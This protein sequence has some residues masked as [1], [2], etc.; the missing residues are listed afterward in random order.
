M[1]DLFEAFF[2]RVCVAQLPQ[3]KPVRPGEWTFMQTVAH[4]TAAA[5]IYLH[6]LEETVQ[7]QTFSLPNLRARTDLARLNEQEIAKRSQL[8]L[9][10]LSGSF[11]QALQKT[12][13]ITQHL[14]VSELSLPVALPI[15]NR[16]LTIAELLDMQIVHPGMLHADQLTRLVGLPPLWKQYSSEF[17]HRQ[18]ARFFQL[19][20]LVYWPERGGTLQAHIKF[21]IAGPGGGR[22]S[23]FIQPVGTFAKE[24]N[25][26]HPTVTLWS[27]HP[28]AFSS[29]LMGQD[30]MPW[31]ILKGR[32]LPSGDL[33]LALQLGRLF[34][35]T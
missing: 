11:L 12:A 14:D 30:R 24:G 26:H 34:N 21:H 8:P 27:P 7:G 1:H 9:S 3:S 5:E 2:E 16:S 20:S 18:L 32:M 28:H 19:M 33:Q 31:P 29:F 35:P 23:L 22:W 4:I 17:M 25:F 10:V 6:A 15:F 13:Q